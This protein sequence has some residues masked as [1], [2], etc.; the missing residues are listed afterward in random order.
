MSGITVYQHGRQDGRPPIVRDMQPG[1]TEVGRIKIGS[2]GE[3]ITT[4]GGKAFQA[5]KKQDYF[6]VTTIQRGTDNNFI[7]DEAIHTQI[8]AKPK[9]IEVRLLF[10]DPWANFQ[11]RYVAYDGKSAWCTGDGHEA[12]RRNELRSTNRAT[13]KV[14]C[15][16]EHLLPDGEEPRCKINGRLAV[17]L[18]HG[19]T[20]GGVWTFRTTSWNSI[21]QLQDS[22]RLLAFATKGQLAGLP[23]V[24]TIRPKQVTMADGRV[25]TIQVVGIEYRGSF[26]ELRQEAER[27]AASDVKYGRRIRTLD[28][29]AKLLTAPIDADDED[30]DVISEFY[31]AAATAAAER[32]TGEKVTILDEAEREDAEEEGYRHL[33]EEVAR[34]DQPK[35]QGAP[36]VEVWD[37]HGEPHEL[38]GLEVEAWLED[39]LAGVAS[40]ETLNGL[41][42][43]NDE[44]MTAYLAERAQRL[45]AKLLAA[46]EAKSTPAT[47]T[48]APAAKK[49]RERRKPK[50][51]A[52]TAAKA[53]PADVPAAEPPAAQ[54]AP[55]DDAD[56]SVI[57]KWPNDKIATIYPAAA[58]FLAAYQR[59]RQFAGAGYESL[60]RRQGP[61]NDAAWQRHVPASDRNPT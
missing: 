49:E 23:F 26:Q 25:N 52:A 58:A 38:P 40:I 5:P 17:L 3:L 35:P 6:T 24:L 1:L 34:H 45:R 51:P 14:A 55:A 9:E 54:A 31:P 46:E 11:S 36:L 20:V 39:Q 4:R 50:E 53:D 18:E 48:P 12:T 33:Q 43:A 2:K 27:A 16:C 41:L 22:L 42:A 37:V 8:G 13:H 60:F 7:R 19:H 29:E 56:Q 15:T 61:A 21:R 47:E 28:A 30:G 59:R 57:V 32:E 44:H 10:N